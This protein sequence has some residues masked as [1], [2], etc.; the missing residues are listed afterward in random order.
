LADGSERVGPVQRG[1]IKRTGRTAP[2]GE[3]HEAKDPEGA[4]GQTEAEQLRG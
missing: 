4:E 3:A 2:A 1:E